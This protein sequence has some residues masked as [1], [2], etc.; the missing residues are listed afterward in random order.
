MLA[1]NEAQERYYEMAFIQ[2]KS[3]KVRTN[4]LKQFVATLQQ[5]DCTTPDFVKYYYSI[6]TI[7]NWDICDHLTI[8]RDCSMALKILKN[9]KGVYNSTL[10]FFARNQ[11]LAHTALREYVQAQALLVDAEKYAPPRSRNLGILRHYQAIVALHSS[12]YQQAYQLYRQ[13]RKSPFKELREQWDIMSAYLYFLKKTGHI[14]TGKDRF[15]IGKYLNETAA[16]ARS[17]QGDKT[18]I[19][20]GELLVYLVDKRSQFI[21]R[22]EATHQF[23]YKALKNSAVRRSRWLLRI[24]CSLPRFHFKIDR[25][26]QHHSNLLAQLKEQPIQIG[27]G[28]TTEFIPFEQL[29]SILAQDLQH[30]V[31]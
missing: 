29:L 3:H 23:S 30:Q 20:I 11:A 4:T 18:N 2:N 1:E 6:R 17:S 27:G 19:L 21:E 14:N 8:K 5:Y 16:V 13:H 15:S 9:K 24:L 26:L 25:A 31:A 12:D 28:Q 22:M 10:Q 7:L